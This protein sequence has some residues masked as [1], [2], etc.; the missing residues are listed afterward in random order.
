MKLVSPIQYPLPLSLEQSAVAAAINAGHSVAVDACAGSGKTHTANYCTYN[1][2]EGVELIP[3][4]RSLREE[5][6]DKFS[7]FGHVNVSN[8]H[9]RG[10]RLCGNVKVDDKKVTAIAT[11]MFDKIGYKVAGLVKAAKTEGYGVCENALSMDAIASKYGFRLTEKEDDNC[12]LSLEEMAEAVLE[13]S[14]K[15][16]STIDYEDMLRLP[17][18]K[19]R[20]ALIPKSSLVILD[21]VQDFTPLAF[22]F[23]REC[24]VTPSHQVLIIGD[25][26]RQALMQFAGASVDLFDTMARYFGCVRLSITENRRCAKSI[27]AAAPFK[28]DMVALSDAPQGEVTTMPENDVIT[29]IC[30]GMYSNDA[31]LSETNAPILRLGIKLITNGTPVRMR[32]N[33]LE[34]L[35][36]SYAYKYIVDKHLPI[37]EMSIKLRDDM[38]ERMDN[39]ANVSEFADFIKCV[40]A[41]ETYCL[42]NGMVKT[43]WRN[44][45]PVHPLQQALEILTSGN[46]GI[47]LMTGHTSKGLEWNTVFHLPANTKAPEQDW[48]VHQSQCL[49]H[50]IAT[51]AKSRFVT[52]VS[53]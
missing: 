45:R 42:A 31:I 10:K 33:K 23:I 28:G 53:E 1:Y 37:G 20:S 49:A 34:S 38:A 48:Q 18:I 16:Q 19:G 44:R 3:F 26:S 9:Q 43:A 41:L 40:E 52:L 12:D 21:E 11:N 36:F 35:L 50:V 25:P 7:D 24:L 15:D 32:T 17:I 4:A 27:V 39:G 22:A 51:R 2:A 8:F 6:S 5:Q 13:K 29:S 47:T 46:E 14:D 30:D